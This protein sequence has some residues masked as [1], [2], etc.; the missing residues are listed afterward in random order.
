M[1]RF[2]GQGP[3]DV[4][5]TGGP[6]YGYHQVAARSTKRVSVRVTVAVIIRY[7]HGLGAFRGL[8]LQV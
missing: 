3:G 2:E 4:S 7:F 6:P 8:G 1:V 5:G